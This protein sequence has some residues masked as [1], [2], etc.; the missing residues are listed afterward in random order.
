MLRAFICFCL[1]GLK[2]R[3]TGITPTGGEWSK[4][5]CEQFFAL[6]SG[7]GKLLLVN[8]LQPK[9]GDKEA[10]I[11]KMIDETGEALID[12]STL[13]KEDNPERKRNKLGVMLK[14]QSLL[15]D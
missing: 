2:C 7:E 1:Q 14:S 15:T 5:A 12:D 8:F 13:G 11:T 3:L 10:Y 9:E 6:V 4:D